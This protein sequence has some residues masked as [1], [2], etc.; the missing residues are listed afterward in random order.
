M[1]LDE[2]IIMFFFKVF[3]AF[4]KVTSIFTRVMYFNE[5][6]NV[7]TSKSNELCKHC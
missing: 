5:Q 2:N 4:T 1:T 6:L 3:T 7:T